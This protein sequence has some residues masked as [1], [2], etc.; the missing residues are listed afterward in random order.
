MTWG[1]FLCPASL[2]QKLQIPQAEPSRQAGTAGKSYI[3][4]T[5]YFTRVHVSTRTGAGL[6]RSMRRELTDANCGGC[7]FFAD[8]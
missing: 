4:M 1:N 6:L 5:M 2:E 8:E 3:L 7:S